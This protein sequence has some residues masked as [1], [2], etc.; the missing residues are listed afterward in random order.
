V[1]NVDISFTELSIFEHWRLNGEP[2]LL[3]GMDVIDKLE[4]FEIDYRQRS[5]HLRAR[6]R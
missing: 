5:L 1:R 4:T 2:A 6:G 3:L